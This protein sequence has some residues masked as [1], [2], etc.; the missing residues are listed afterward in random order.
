MAFKWL[1]SEV[2]S[3]WSGTFWA[4]FTSKGSSIVELVTLIVELIALIELVVDWY[5]SLGACASGS[6]Q[7]HAV[8]SQSIWL[9]SWWAVA[10]LV[11]VLSVSENLKWV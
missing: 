7:S 3:G 5:E 6:D 9:R 11:A 2:V 8:S 1:T 4:F 10:A